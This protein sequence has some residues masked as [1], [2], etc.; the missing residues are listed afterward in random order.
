MKMHRAVTN[1]YRSALER[2]SMKNYPIKL[3]LLFSESERESFSKD[4][5]RQRR[6]TLSTRREMTIDI[7]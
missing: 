7:G 1:Y 4:Q 6:I 3:H 5:S 2:S